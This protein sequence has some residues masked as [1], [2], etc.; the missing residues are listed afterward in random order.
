MDFVSSFD[1]QYNP[2][3]DCKL[4]RDRVNKLMTYFTAI[5]EVLNKKKAILIKNNPEKAK[6]VLN[7]LASK[8]VV[9]PSQYT[10]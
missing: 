2:L 3:G 7:K 5:I 6:E 10:F 4:M 8:P 1:K 9:N